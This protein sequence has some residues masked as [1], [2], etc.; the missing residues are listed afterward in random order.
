MCFLLCTKSCPIGLGCP[1]GSSFAR[2]GCHLL[3]CNQK[4][5]IFLVHGS[6]SSTK[7]FS[8]NLCPRRAASDSYHART[9]PRAWCTKGNGEKLHELE[10][11]QKFTV[12]R[13]HLTLYICGLACPLDHHSAN[14]GVYKCYLHLCTA[15]FLQE[16]VW[17]WYQKT[18]TKKSCFSVSLDFQNRPR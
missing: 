2:L 9:I 11:C 5:Y 15:C 13:S 8:M 1:S 7:G 18:S 10:G 4:S 17:A 3:N 6:P 16:T 14:A 12:V